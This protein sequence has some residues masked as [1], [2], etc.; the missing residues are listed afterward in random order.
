MV[1]RAGHLGSDRSR[2]TDGEC[3][4]ATLDREAGIILDYWL[5]EH[6]GGYSVSG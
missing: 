1:D 5:L 6:L 2:A 3:L 4:K